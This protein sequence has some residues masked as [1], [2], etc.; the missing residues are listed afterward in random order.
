M[1]DLVLPHSIASYECGADLLLKPEFYL[2]FCQEMAE[3]HA[4]RN[5]MGYDWVAEH[6]KLW[7]EVQG[8]FELLRR[9][10]W[11][12]EVSL[13]TNTGQAS[14]LQARRFV[15]M[16]DKAG[17][18]I[19]R[20]DLMWVIIDMNTRRPVPLKRADLDVPAVC[21]P[22][23]TAEPLK[24]PEDQAEDLGTAYFV[25]SRRDIDFNGHINNSAYLTWAI[26]TM[27][28]S[29]GREPR[30][31]HVAYK[32][33]SMVGEPLC[34]VHRAAGLLSQHRIE[35]GGKLRAIITMEWAK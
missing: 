9:P 3:L 7:V 2:L 35:G 32:H 8:D 15:E 18:V 26:D 31:I 12:E 25:T 11:K 30:R 10:K 34:V 22:S 23:I 14:P 20:A 1:E 19:G 6:G 28:N 21:P 13:R 27:P 29:L 5:K 16:S 24:F 17:E 4:S 33:E